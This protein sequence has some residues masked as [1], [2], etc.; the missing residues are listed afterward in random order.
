LEIEQTLRRFEEGLKIWSIKLNGV[1]RECFQKLTKLLLEWNRKLNLT[2]ITDPERI[3]VE[4][5]LDSVAPLAFNLI[6]EGVS[7]VDVGTGA[8]FP[9]L[10]LAI[11][12]PLSK[13][14]LVDATRKK[15]AYL[16]VVCSELE[17][18]NVEVVWGRAEE[19]ASSEVF[20]ERFDVAMARA[21]GAL[22]ILWECTL[23]FVKVGGVAIAYKGAR[24]DEELEIGKQTA[25][26]I[27]GEVIE[28][29][30]FKLPATR[31]NRSLVVAAKVANTPPNLPRRSGIPQK[32][33]LRFWIKRFQR[34]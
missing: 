6:G 15:V 29:H 10:P 4:H 14:T 16:Q 19:L 21:F 3:A 8:G 24:V 26:L 31:L 20:R 34:K 13:F 23:P 2:R 30:R 9:G 5:Y 12:M 28:V 22:D 11:L 1:Q 32:R 27:G 18:A 25:T 17:L 33:P 7:V